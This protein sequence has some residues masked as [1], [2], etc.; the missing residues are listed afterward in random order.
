MSETMDVLFS[1]LFGAITAFGATPKTAS[2]VLYVLYPDHV[3]LLFGMLAFALGCRVIV[4]P[5]LGGLLYTCAVS[6]NGCICNVNIGWCRFNITTNMDSSGYKKT[7]SCFNYMS[8]KDSK[9]W[10]GWYVHC[11]CRNLRFICRINNRSTTR[12]CN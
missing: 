9:C 2:S 3:S 5:S 8:I 1:F 7:K 10:Y 4:R 6:R 11:D 12:L